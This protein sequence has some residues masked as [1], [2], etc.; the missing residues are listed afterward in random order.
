MISKENTKNN[1]RYTSITIQQLKKKDI[2]PG[3]PLIFIDS[4]YFK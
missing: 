4:I 1:R 3:I 2:K